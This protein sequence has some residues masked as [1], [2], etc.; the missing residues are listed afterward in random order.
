MNALKSRG[1]GPNSARFLEA[2]GLIGFLATAGGQKLASQK[3]L[4]T[5]MLVGGD[6]PS[7]SPENH[8][9]LSYWMF[10]PNLTWRQGGPHMVSS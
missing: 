1:T 7:M 9:S 5:S 6:T 8:I 4:C 3:G 2:T 10:G